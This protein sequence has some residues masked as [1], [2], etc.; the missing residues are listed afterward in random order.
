MMD[1]LL[2]C[3]LVAMHGHYEVTKL[4]LNYDAKVDSQENNGWS[5]LMIASQNGHYEVAELLLENGAKVDL[6]NNNGWSAL[7]CANQNRQ[8]K[9][10]K[11]LLE[12]NQ[13]NFLDPMS[14]KANR[15]YEEQKLVMNNVH[16]DFQEANT[17]SA[18]QLAMKNTKIVKEFNKDQHGKHG[19]S[20]PVLFITSQQCHHYI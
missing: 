13:G 5:A 1:V 4:L 15:R 3:F 7:K 20:L 16:S 11:L 18:L 2:S 19:S 10:A 9:V 6:L 14:A 12:N 17:V 8:F